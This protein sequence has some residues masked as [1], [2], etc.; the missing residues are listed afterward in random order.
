MASGDGSGGN[1]I[2]SSRGKGPAIAPGSGSAGS[3]GNQ[4]MV[5]LVPCA[6]GSASSKDA[7]V[8][9]GSSRDDGARASSKDDSNGSQA[10]AK[11]ASANV[12]AAIPLAARQAGPEK[13]KLAFTT[14]IRGSSEMK[15]T[16]TSGAPTEGGKEGG[17]PGKPFAVQDKA[18]AS[19]CEED[20][21]KGHAR[22]P[23][24]PSAAVEGVDVKRVKGG[25]G[26]PG[27]GAG[28]NEETTQ[29]RRFGWLGLRG[30]GQ[31]NA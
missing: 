23:S 6:G 17:T 20:P 3:S 27:D 13:G 28:E 18:K 14:P 4:A 21:K 15:V 7:P 22:Q 5:R 24:G 12:A 16:P 29:R 26:R 2:S 31:R 9:T 25:G 10:T 19:C 11:L 8:T 30:S 1:R